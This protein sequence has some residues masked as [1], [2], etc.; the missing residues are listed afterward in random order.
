MPEETTLSTNYVIILVTTSSKQEA[1][2]IAQH[3]LEDRLIA[4]A[5]IVGPVTSIYQ[6]SEK[7]E[8]AEEFL[9]ILKSGKHLFER[10]TDVV[11]TMHSYEVP[12][13][14]SIPV[15]E[16]SKT[17]LDWLQRCLI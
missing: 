17:Y 4:C 1:E 11:K 14:L 6:W 8:K 3:L 15:E 7:I 5:N 16:G 12:E 2:R 10:V 13:I 9:M